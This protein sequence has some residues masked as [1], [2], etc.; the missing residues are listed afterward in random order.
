M[1]RRAWGAAHFAAF[2]IDIPLKAIAVGCRPGGKVLDPFMGSGTVGIAAWQLGRKFLGIDLNADYCDLVPASHRDP[3][4]GSGR[5]P[6]ISAHQVALREG[7]RFP[8]A[9]TRGG[10]MRPLTFAD[11]QALPAVV[12]LLL[13]ARAL[14]LSRNAAYRLVQRDE[15]PCRAIKVGDT[16]RVP[17]IELLVLI[18]VDRENVRSAFGSSA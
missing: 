16:Y 13:A 3:V 6:P 11:V 10:F 4:L 7:L 14:V 8:M 12:P 2:P 15:F 18:G 9:E 5:H 1:R 17:T